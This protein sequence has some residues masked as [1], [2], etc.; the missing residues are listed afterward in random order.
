MKLLL[1]TIL[2]SSTIILSAQSKGKA[3]TTKEEPKKELIFTET[4]YSALKFRSVGPALVSGRIS[5]IAVNPKNAYQWY[6]AVASGGV[7]KTDN[8]GT[9]FYPIFDGQSSFSIGCVTLDPTNE[10][11]VWVGSGENNNQRS[12]AYGDGVYK[13]EDGGKSWNNVGL[14]NSEHIGMIAIHPTNGNVVFVAAYGPLWSK[15]GE[16]GIYKTVDGGKTWK[17][18]LFVS[19]NTGFNEV[20]ID[21]KN[22]NTLYA[23]AHQRRRHEW[24]YLSGGPESAIYKSTDGGETWNKLTNG[25]PSGDKGRIGMAVSPV[26]SDYLYAI[27]EGSK[28]DRGFYKSTNRGASW[29]K[30]S[31]HNTSGNYYSE[32]VADPI[33]VDKVYSLDT[34]T[35]VTLDGG[36]TFK[37][38][39]EK[40]KH[41]DN[42]ALWIDPNN[43]QHMLMGCD[44]GLYETWDNC[45][46]WNF[47]PNL[48]I[49]QFYRVTVDNATP[50]Y[51]IYGGTQDN[52]TLGG[53]SRTISASGIVNS[54]WFITVGGDGFTAKVDPK[55]PTLCILN[56]NMEV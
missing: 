47:K 5:D 56:G 3:T 49:T 29:E 27:V 8:A 24:T 17:Q 46:H 55:D 45:A 54:D 9:T 19:E 28:E 2:V 53:P 22:P 13:S 12:V 26:N 16:R 51:N 34:Y 40:N 20:H 30:Q 14:K 39:G 48:P 36:K 31:G 35:Q 7:W 6:I 18:V 38:V 23:T 43:T 37:Y 1:T 25:L 52:N 32:I 42:H 50:F 4:T 33:N 21:P 41:V 44:G 10:N 11:V 15:G